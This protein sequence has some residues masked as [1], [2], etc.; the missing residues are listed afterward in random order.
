VFGSKEKLS[1]TD[2]NIL[3]SAVPSSPE[4]TKK[5]KSLRKRF[6]AFFSSRLPSW[7]RRGK[8]KLNVNTSA[9]THYRQLK[10]NDYWSSDETR[11]NTPCND[12][13]SYDEA[14]DDDM[15][16]TRYS[17]RSRSRSR[18]D[19]GSDSTRHN[20]EM[21][22]V[23]FVSLE[24]IVAVD[25]NYGGTSDL[26]SSSSSSST[27]CSLRLRTRLVYETPEST[28]SSA[29]ERGIDDVDG[30]GMNRSRA[31]DE[32][33]ELSEATLYE[34]ALQSFRSVISTD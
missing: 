19:S 18:E 1:E 20:S 10:Q 32:G 14:Q 21:S 4:E 24:S 3:N 22:S 6:V 7:N 30:E 12:D 23:R 29:S 11:M 27:S 33:D 16:S 31:E 15:S 2:E 9:R 5:K 28:L 34:N 17:S 13:Q 8:D 26:L 25:D